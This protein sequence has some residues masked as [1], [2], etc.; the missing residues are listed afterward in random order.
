MRGAFADSLARAYSPISAFIASARAPIPIVRIDRG[1]DILSCHAKTIQSAPA[2]GP[3]GQVFR[4]SARHGPD[5]RDQP[6][7]G[8]RRF[9]PHLKHA[10]QGR[11]DRHRPR[12]GR[13]LFPLRRIRLRADRG[14]AGRQISCSAR[15]TA[16]NARQRQELAHR[17]SEINRTAKDTHRGAAQI[18]QPNSKNAARSSAGLIPLPVSAFSNFPRTPAHRVIR[19]SPELRSGAWS[20]QGGAFDHRDI[21]HWAIRNAVVIALVRGD[22]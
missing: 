13:A 12:H 9:W 4:H 22:M 8:R 5:D 17:H 16:G 7:P 2:P 11:P 20:T 6:R 3:A 19:A 14:Q 15:R 10:Q 21:A 18:S 1:R